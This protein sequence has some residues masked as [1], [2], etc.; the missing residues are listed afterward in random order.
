MRYDELRDRW[1]EAL[2]AARVMSYQDRP[3]ESI[4]VT[5][6]TRKWKVYLI[7]TSVEPFHTGA[8]IGFRWDPFESARSYTCEEDLLREL[9][10]RESRRSTQQRLVRVDFEFRAALHYGSTTPLPA[11]EVWRSWVAATE[12]K[13][14][15]AL[16]AKRRRKELVPE[17]RG[18]LEIGG[19]TSPEGVFALQDMSV[20]AFEMLAIPRIWDDPGRQQRERSAGARIDDLANRLR[21]ALD[22]WAAS[23]GDL[24]Q[25]FPSEPGS[26]GPASRR[27]H[28]GRLLY[29]DDGGPVTIH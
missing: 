25:W 14:D 11:P 5:S 2:R 16:A 21:G 15:G 1:Q 23:V 3:E 28:P 4:D 9:L 27:R 24:V 12:G 17:W 18:D 13:L 26:R 10:G 7:P 19:H 20:R 22:V 6:M 8:T 29:E